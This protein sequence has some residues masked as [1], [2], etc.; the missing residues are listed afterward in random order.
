MLRPVYT[1]DFCCDFRCDFLLLEDGKEWMS[2]KCS[3]LSNLIITTLSK[4]LLHIFQKEKIAT[5]IAAKIARVNGPLGADYLHEEFL[6]RAEFQ[7][8]YAS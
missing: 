1:G 4:P 3:R 5:K 7:I 2:Y 6:A 8:G